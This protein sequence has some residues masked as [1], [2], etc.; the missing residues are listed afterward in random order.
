M[1]EW[2]I[3]EEERDLAAV[4]AATDKALALDAD[5]VRANVLLGRLLALDMD[6]K[7]DFTAAA[8]REVRKP[9]AHAN[10]TNPD[11]PV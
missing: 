10:R 1:A 4:R 11:D 9:I 8:W 2:E 3:D 5:H 6:K 7:N